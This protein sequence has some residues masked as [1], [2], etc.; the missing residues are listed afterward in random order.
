[1]NHLVPQAS[2]IGT[3]TTDPDDYFDPETHP[4]TEAC[5]WNEHS[6]IS[7]GH[8]ATIR[9]R[10][11]KAGQAK[12]PMGPAHEDFDR[13]RQAA[14]VA[15]P[16]NSRSAPSPLT[17]VSDEA[18]VY[19]QT[20]GEAEFRQYDAIVVLRTRNLLTEVRYR[21]AKKGVSPPEGITGL[22]QGAIQISQ[23]IAAALLAGRPVTS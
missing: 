23:W 2:V 8:G 9:T 11:V 19:D 4:G 21:W 20:T 6:Y 22:R 3:P 14:A 13:L 15:G 17:G 5:E 7:F 12:D 10:P 18:F 1:M 16:Q